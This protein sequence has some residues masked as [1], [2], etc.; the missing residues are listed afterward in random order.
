MLIVGT[1]VSRLTTTVFEAPAPVATA[2][3]ASS[4]ATPDRIA[5]R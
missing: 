4:V 3:G 1:S 5:C 2:A